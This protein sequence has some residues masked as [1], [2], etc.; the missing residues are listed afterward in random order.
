MTKLTPDQI[1]EELIHKV[2]G[3]GYTVPIIEKNEEV[4]IKLIGRVL[5]VH[6]NTI[7]VVFFGDNPHVTSQ[8]IRNAAS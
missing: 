6:D 7:K 2:N 5:T 4:Q 8:Q 1:R 3:H